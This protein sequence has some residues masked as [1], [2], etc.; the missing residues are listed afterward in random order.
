[1]AR[2]SN[3][4]TRRFWKDLLDRTGTTPGVRSVALSSQI[5]MQSAAASLPLV[6]EDWQMLRSENSITT[7]GAYVSEGFFSTL[8]IPILQG[9]DFRESDN[10][11]SPLV[12]V[13]NAQMA[14]HFWKGDALGKR[15]QLGT[16]SPMVQIVGIV[17]TCKYIWIGE[18]PVDFAYM[19]YRQHLESTMSLAVESAAQDANAIA[20]ALRAVVRS[21]DPVM[22][23]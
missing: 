20:P 7:F 1:M 5:P 2:Y 10:Q 11:N 4:Q 14:A 16:G 15:F 18:A 21:L 19:P 6:P 12:A 13:V 22:P 17:K 9:R 23:I 3:D 8:R